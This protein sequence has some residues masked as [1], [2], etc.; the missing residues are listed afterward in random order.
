MRLDIAGPAARAD[1]AADEIERL[2]ARSGRDWYAYGTG[3]LAR[4]NALLARGAPAP[5]SAELA[6]LITRAMDL[7][8]RSGGLFDPGV[9]A[10]VRLWQFDS[11]DSLAVAAA[12]PRDAELAALRARQGTLGDLRFDGHTATSARP[13]CIDLGGMAKGTALERARRLLARHGIDSALLDVGG[14]SQLAV[15]R[16]G[17][18]AWSIGLRDPRSDRILARLELAPGEAASTSGDYERGYVRDGRRYHHIL[19]PATGRPTTGTASVT[20]LAGDA[21]L[22]DAASTALMVAG[23]GRFRD[24]ATALGISTALLITTGGELLATPEMSQRLQRDNGGR[25]PAPSW[26]DPDADL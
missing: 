24:V 8:A 11:E 2:F 14:S 19:D 5:V 6:P 13:L 12:P 1:P 17:R 18:R 15:G 22:A 10:L 7:H 9:C 16:K 20:V 3:E 23:P 4:V 21:E 26:G 25:L